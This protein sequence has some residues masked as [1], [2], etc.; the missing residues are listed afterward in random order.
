MPIGY[1]P[2]GS[3]KWNTGRSSGSAATKVKTNN[4]KMNPKI[5]GIWFGACLS[6]GCIP[7]LIRGMLRRKS[8]RAN[9][10]AGIICQRYFSTTRWITI[11]RIAK[12]GIKFIQ[13]DFLIDGKENPTKLTNSVTRMSIS[14]V[15]TIILS[16]LLSK[17]RLCSLI[18][19][20]LLHW[21]LICQSCHTFMAIE[22]KSI[23]CSWLN[24]LD[25]GI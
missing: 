19:T 23:F 18:V 21:C 9:P 3:G 10:Y 6:A 7:F 8:R 24:C 11:K 20:P 1:G 13:R 22:Q 4:L 16:N 14:N 25:F 15:R 12:L 17:F 2:V 5:T